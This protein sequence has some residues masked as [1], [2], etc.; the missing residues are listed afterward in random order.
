MSGLQPV[1]LPQ[2]ASAAV[3]GLADHGE[4]VGLEHGAHRHTVRAVVIDDQ[5]GPGHRGPSW[6]PRGTVRMGVGTY[7]SA[8]VAG[9]RHAP[10]NGHHPL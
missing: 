8:G 4:A 3:P 1:G 6:Q 2:I 7:V 5:D 9:S 10:T